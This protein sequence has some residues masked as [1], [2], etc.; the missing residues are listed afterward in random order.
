M[1]CT[2][3]IKF[4]KPAFRNRRK[5]ETIVVSGGR[6]PNPWNKRPEWINYLKYL[7]MC[8]HRR[9]DSRYRRDKMLARTDVPNMQRRKR[10]RQL[11][12]AAKALW[13]V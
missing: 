10:Q 9:A 4:H 1:H 13:K 5:P 6:E 8:P 12:D 7:R 2:S 11:T 3:H